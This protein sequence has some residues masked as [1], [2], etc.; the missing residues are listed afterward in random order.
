MT[1]PYHVRLAVTQYGDQFRTELFTEDLGD[2]EGDLLPELPPSLGEWVPYLSQ[3]ADLPPDAARQ[4]G[5]DLFAALLGQPENAK[6][7]AEVL[8]QAERSGRP[9]RL[10]IDATTDAVRD[11]PYGLLCEPHDDWFLFRGGRKQSVAFVRILRRCS[12]RPLRL[13][14]RLRVLLAVAEPRSPD[15]PAFDAPLRVQKLCAA[16]RDR[17]DLILCGPTGPRPAPD[18]D[19]AAFAPFT[20]TTREGLRKA[21]AAD[22]D[23]FHL[24][25]HGH[26]AGVLLCDAAGG[27]AETTASELAEWCGAGRTPLAFLQVCKAGATA[28]RGGFG[29]VAQQL[30]SPRGGNLAAVVASTFPLDAEY[31]THAAVGF[32][33][34][35][36]A[37][38]P[39]EVALT[40]D[41]PETDWSWA[42]LELWARPGAL[43][44]T[45]QRAAFQ[46]VSP[47]RG[48]SSFG[49]R[50]A[51]LFFGRRAEVKELLNI[52]RTDPV[53]AVV[54]DSGSGKSSLLQA[55]LVHAIRREG[56]L[57]STHWR[58]VSLR[59]GYRPGQALLAALSGG[60]PDSP[61]GGYGR[62]SLRESATVSA[63]NGDS[64]DT[65]NR[66]VYET[67]AADLDHLRRALRAELRAG[68]Q[69]LLV[70]FDQLEELF[71]LARERTEVDLVTE[72]LAAA[73]DEMPDRFRWVI[74]MRS[75]FLGQAASIPGLG[76]RV[77]RPWVLRPPGPDTLK[78]IV[79]GP[80]EACGYTFQGTLRDGDPRHAI[81]LLD[82]I[83]A[84]PLLAAG[85]GA[86]AP[87]PLLQFALER[88]WLRAVDRG[89]T[90]FTHTEFD[91]VGGLGKAIAQHA[92]AVFQAAPTATALGP[93]AR[94]VAEQVITGLVSTQATRQPRPRAALQAEAG[95]AEAARAVIDYLVGERLLTVRS[96][97]EDLSK[98]LVDLSHEALIEH[99][100]RLR[101]WLAED[102]AGRAMREEFRKHAE[103]WAAGFAGVPPRSRRGL[104]GPDV[105]NNYLTWIRASQPKLSPAH[106]EFAAALRGLLTRRRRVRQ[107]VLGALTALAL[108]SSV[109]AIYAAGQAAKA[110]SK[111]SVATA[112]EAEARE[113]EAAAL[114]QS[115]ALTLDRG[116]ELCE[117]GR[118]RIGMLSIARSLET[119]PPGATDLR[120]VILTNL[121]AW[122]RH[123]LRLDDARQFT[124]PAVA[125]SPDGRAVLVAVAEGVVQLF[126]ID[127]GQPLGREF[128]PGAGNMTWGEVMAEGKGWVVLTY[129]SKA[130]RLW[131]G[132]DGEPRG[133]LTELAAARRAGDTEP[134]GE[135]LIAAIRPDRKGVATGTSE[136]K[137]WVW[138]L[139]DVRPEQPPFKF[140]PKQPAFDHE[141]PVHD[142]AFTPD[143]TSLLTGCGRRPDGHL[144][145]DVRASKWGVDPKSA[146]VARLTNL[147]TRQIEW[148]YGMEDPVTSV[149]VSP[150]EKGRFLAVG[151][152]DVIAY[153]RERKALTG[154]RMEDDEPATWTAF[155]PY[156]QGTMFMS[157]P[158]GDAQILRVLDERS[159]TGERLSPQGL[160]V[161]AGFRKDRRVFTVNRDGTVR[162]WRRPRVRAAAREFE[163][164]DAVLSA[165]FTPDGTGA[166]AG[167]RNGLVYQS[168]LARPGAFDRTYRPDT[169][170]AGHAIT[171][172]RVSPDGRH[173]IA[174]DLH[175][176][177]YVW[178]RATGDPVRPPRGTE[179]VGVADDGVRALVRLGTGKYRV[180]DLLTGTA[181]A[182]IFVPGALTPKPEHSDDDTA[183]LRVVRVAFS[184]DGARLATIDGDGRVL[185]W[186]ARTGAPVGRPL[187]HTV[188]NQ[189]ERIRA[190]RFSPD[191]SRV[192]T[193]SFRAR[194]VW[195]A[196]TTDNE[197]L[198]HN[199]VGVQISRFSPCGNM[200]LSGTNYNMA[201]IFDIRER[202]LR[203]VALLHGAQVW[204]ITASAD[205]SRVLTASYDQTARSWDAVTG[206][207]LSP[208]LRHDEGVSDVVYSPEGAHV[209]TASWDRKVRLWPKIDPVP[210][211][212]DRVTAWV[213]TWTGL[214]IGLTGSSDLLTAEEWAARKRKLDDLGGPP[215]AD[216]RPAEM[217]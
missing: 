185:V 109:L 177:Q 105:A 90:E 96:D 212:P 138:D 184:P 104:P 168:D 38:K 134:V 144:L 153:D 95:D 171:Q 48:L 22:Y 88:L 114:E 143:G 5:K 47:Y 111:E 99:W 108:A 136:G 117:A 17:V 21:L 191:G 195:N 3:G 216:D 119:C 34:Q 186:D 131:N 165:A 49:E 206:K 159:L 20:T 102:P 126:D 164:P 31:S 19:P 75:E 176:R 91:A 41:R 181:G 36:A 158:S 215:V 64:P 173:V 42:F 198:F 107:A 28:G 154:G 78:D 29:G 13:R 115:T 149:G 8:V 82:R 55:G 100:D 160:I 12:P 81:G 141:G 157:R 167:C 44:G 128:E 89:L 53:V 60:T 140:R 62:A 68:D 178:T 87:L 43:G 127:S 208:S 162:L 217:R 51:D 14:D 23:V 2:T 152:F 6:K 67:T 113:S 94:S 166:V 188:R 30:L 132:T 35:L 135:I 200:I 33:E 187:T 145:P 74:G 106:R 84:D 11:L 24:L 72:A 7:W 1:A 10:L 39:P 76:P 169:V 214:R 66:T 26:G 59:P 180:T 83:L 210:D 122:S 71:T 130:F 118:A 112:K 18:G 155:D 163:Y 15:V 40:A 183:M 97:P 202:K 65:A 148:A 50:D 120:R 192:L 205:G 179:L 80:A 25:A 103:Q 46:F 213:E 211:E 142:L 170:G 58:I 121:A 174:Q 69:P 196:D 146:G 27:P 56:L 129:G 175:F 9:V 193:Q 52:L 86:P 98:S 57:D 77:R 61:S 147:E 133:P 110:R 79:A 201:Q 150:D 73:A 16:L 54:G 199:P 207:P 194:A 45:Q 203:P 32:Y 116:I 156:E 93:A 137:V 172:V 70:V 85:S 101:G 182:E 189:T 161:G 4:L 37:G 209:L 63:V 197:H 139:V 125:A 190:V 204:G 123:L 92:E 151:G 124:G